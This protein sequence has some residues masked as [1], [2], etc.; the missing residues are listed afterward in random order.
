MLRDRPADGGQP[1]DRD[2]QQHAVGERCGK[3]QGIGSEQGPGV[4]EHD[5]AADGRAEASPVVIVVRRWVFVWRGLG[6]TPTIPDRLHVLALR[7]SG[8]PGPGRVG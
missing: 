6:T 5:Q 4:G 3:R 2:P 8:S 7:P 1:Q